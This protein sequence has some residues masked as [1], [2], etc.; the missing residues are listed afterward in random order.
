[1]EG[2]EY[3]RRAKLE[4]VSAGLSLEIARAANCLSKLCRVWVL[5]NMH[6][7]GSFK[8]DIKSEISVDRIGNIRAVERVSVLARTCS[9]DV[10]GSIYSAQYS[11]GEGQGA[12][13]IIGAQGQLFHLLGAD[14]IGGCSFS[15][16]ELAFFVSHGY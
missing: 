1:M 8:W 5:F 3:P 15:R 2:G 12:L 9:L 13:V 16:T 7:G 10:I 4:L 14:S 11:R 6:A